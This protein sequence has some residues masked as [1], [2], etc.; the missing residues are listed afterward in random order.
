MVKCPNCGAPMQDGICTYC[1]FVENKERTSNKINDAYQ[2]S[3]NNTYSFDRIGIS[4][5]S[6]T[7]AF[8]LCFFLGF[9]GAHKFYVGKILM[10]ILYFFTFGFFGIGWIIDVIL[11]LMGSFKD[12]NNL[13]LKK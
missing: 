7:V 3:S 9:T 6:K 10:G 8:I 5:K 2:Y 12:N 11:I 13:L 1:H 4:S